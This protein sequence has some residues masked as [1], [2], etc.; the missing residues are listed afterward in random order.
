MKLM[1]C[2]SNLIG[3]LLIKAVTWSKWSHVAILIDDKTAIEAVHPAVRY[4]GVSN[5]KA[6]YKHWCIVDV[7][8]HDEAAA[9]EYAKSQIAKP[10]DYT[11]L[12]GIF[13]HR[14]WGDP[15]NWYCAELAASTVVNG[16]FRLFRRKFINRIVPQHLWMLDFDIVEASQG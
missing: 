9:I 1:F 11:A 3:A 14:D 10:Y 4:V 5:L 6:K 2:S 13:F 8:V 7:P 12:A 15:A 16:G